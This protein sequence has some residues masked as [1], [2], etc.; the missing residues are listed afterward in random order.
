MKITL[1]SLLAILG[2]ASC[3]KTY[4]NQTVNQVYSAVYTIPTTSWTSS[5]GGTV[6][7]AT[8]AIAELDQT[9]VDQGGV[10]VYLSFDAN[11]PVTYE[12]IPEVVNG[13]AYG[14]FFNVGNIGIDLQD[15]SGA[16]VSAPGGTI[17]AKVVLLDGISLD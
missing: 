10:Q 11:T 6:Q 12:G 1:F 15:V 4:V 3:K 17:F 14:S 7:T 9:I 5:Q 13:I 8:L 16:A 2:L